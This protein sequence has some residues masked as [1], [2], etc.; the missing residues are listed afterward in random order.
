MKVAESP[1]KG[2][3]APAAAEQGKTVKV[4]CQLDSAAPLAGGFTAKLDGL[5]P[6]AT[7]QPVEVKTGASQI[8]FIVVVDPTSPVGE[9]RSLVCE[10]FGTVGGQ[11]AVYRIGRPGTLKVDVAGGVKTD[12]G[13]KPLSPLEALRWSRRKTSRRSREWKSSRHT[14]CA[15]A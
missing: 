15:V 7:A 13:G 8:E 2:L 10:L 14:P 9:H 1:V 11:K 5:P 3:F 4:V 12:A 6:R